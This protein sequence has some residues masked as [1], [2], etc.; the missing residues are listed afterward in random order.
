[1][2]E[3][4]EAEHADHS[5]VLIDD[6]KPPNALALHKARCFIRAAAGSAPDYTLC[7]DISGSEL[8]N[9]FSI[10]NAPDGDVPICH[11]ADQ[12]VVLSNRKRTC[13][14]VKIAPNALQTV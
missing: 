10:G 7:H 12:P 11:H 3:V 5:F 13:S 4:A 2:G 14:D 1:M 6:R 8:G 9:I